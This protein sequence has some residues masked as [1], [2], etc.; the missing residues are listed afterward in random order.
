MKKIFL[1]LIATLTLASCATNEPLDT[2]LLTQQSFE[3]WLAK[4]DPQ[5]VKFDGN[6]DIYIRFSERGPELTPADTAS[7]LVEYAWYRLKYSAHTLDGN[8]VAT[9]DSLMSK[10]IGYWQPS[11]HWVDAYIHHYEDNTFYCP[12]LFDVVSTL[13]PGDKVRVYI[14]SG[15]GYNSHYM[16]ISQGYMG[17]EYSSQMG[18]IIYFDLQIGQVNHDAVQAQKDSLAKYIAAWGLE[19]KD[20]LKNGLY[21]RTITANP[22]GDTITPDTT[23][24]LKYT[25]YF[26]DGFMLSTNDYE[27]ALA[28]GRVLEDD[29]SGIPRYGWEQM[30]PTIESATIPLSYEE[31]IASMRKGETAEFYTL[32][33]KSRYEDAGSFNYSTYDNEYDYQPEVGA[34]QPIRFVLTIK[35]TVVSY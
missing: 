14:T 30:L 34:F 4:N 33:Y 26:P 19:M 11:T 2:D 22:L 6:D 16:N 25:E 35:D 28:L 23:I 15:E 1:S 12:G 31:A 21:K 29:E 24:Q 10:L 5:A 8:V 3:A 17:N 7:T 18:S 9:R 20:S 32:A 13:R 27:V